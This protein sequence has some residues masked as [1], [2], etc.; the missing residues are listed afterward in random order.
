M[1]AHFSPPGPGSW[2]R[3]ADHF[4]GALTP[5]YQALYTETAGPGM[6]DYMR[7]Y[8]V[9]ANG[10]DIAYVH[11]HLYIA[12]IPLAGPREMRRTP[13]AAAVWLMARL[14][15]AF[16]HRNRAA[17]QTLAERPWRAVTA[18]WFATE[19]DQW[20]E[21][22]S[23]LE[24][25][26]PAQMTTQ[27][28]RAHL[29]AC[30]A[31]VHDGYT[32]HFQLHGD[33]MLPVGLL[34][35]RCSEWG[36][37]PQ[38]T[39]QALVGASPVSAGTVTPHEWQ[40]V[41]GYDLDALAWCELAAQPAAQQA[42]A[43]QPLD[44]R[45]LVPPAHHLELA[46]LVSDAR[47]AVPLRDDNG[48]YT[49]AWPMGLLR[50]A[51]LAAGR[52]LGFH[53]PGLAIEATVAE[54]TERI[55]GADHPDE[56][57][58]EVRRTDRLRHSA[59]DAPGRLGPEFVL[60]PLSALPRPLALIGAAQLASSDHMRGFGT[61]VGIGSVSYTGRAL[62]V[63][64]PTTAFDLIEPGDV[65]VTAFTSPSWNAVLVQAGAIVTTTGG[66]A[67]HASVM[68]RELAIPAVLGD[69]GAM[70]RVRTGMT[71]TVDPVRASVEIHP[72]AT[73]VI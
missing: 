38:I 49:G 26:Q 54:L 41:T 32:R 21:R 30:R 62:V 16:R 9:L 33:D 51:M 19:R 14:H 66:L 4:P 58:L 69:A 45:P 73:A 56:S 39:M 42:P 55:D 52:H 17:R 28:L 50:R 18:H 13:P 43:P 40:L 31:L 5:E 61:A 72:T 6:A 1:T 36:V 22:A 53:D 20:T 15:P 63:D 35:T 59:F 12:P 29:L 34:I 46:E 64:D 24:A 10:L 27:A 37:D 44:L 67:S 23:L 47:A 71:V 3:L 57:A 11:G 60:P 7:R 2:M 25:E 68:A 48:I 70:Q 65:V 8:G